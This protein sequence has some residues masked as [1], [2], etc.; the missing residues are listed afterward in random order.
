MELEKCIRKSKTPSSKKNK[1]LVTE[2]SDDCSQS[3]NCRC[4]I[5]IVSKKL[6]SIELHTIKSN[7]F[8]HFEALNTELDREYKIKIWKESYPYFKDLVSLLN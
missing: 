5:C 2:K 4:S 7:S 8:N 3:R 6:R 1:S